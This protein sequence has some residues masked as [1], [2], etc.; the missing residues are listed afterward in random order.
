MTVEGRGAGGA[1]IVMLAVVSIEEM[2]MEVLF[3]PARA[4]L[5]IGRFSYELKLEESDH[6]EFFPLK[7]S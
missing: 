4:L 3:A 2:E 5:K 7:W 1:V 6:G